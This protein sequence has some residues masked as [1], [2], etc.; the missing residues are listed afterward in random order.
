MTQFS[1]LERGDIRYQESR[2][3]IGQ[4]NDSVF[5]L[6]GEPTGEEISDIR[7]HKGIQ[8]VLISSS[9]SEEISEPL[10]EEI[11]EADIRYQAT[12]AGSKTLI[13]ISAR[14]YQTG[15]DIKISAS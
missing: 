10:Q 4:T 9:Y 14:R 1:H 8:Q 13:L 3:Q 11:F 12:V 5:T 6:R 15:S 2:Y 7:Y